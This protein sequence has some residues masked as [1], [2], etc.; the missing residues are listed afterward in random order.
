MP[1]W[2]GYRTAHGE[3]ARLAELG[4]LAIGWGRV[5]VAAAPR[6]P[7][8]SRASSCGPLHGRPY[9]VMLAVEEQPG[10]IPGAALRLLPPSHPS[11]HHGIR[12]PARSCAAS[13]RL[14]GRASAGLPP[15]TSCRPMPGCS[16]SSCSILT[17]RCQ[18][19]EFA[20]MGIASME[21][22]RL[23]RPPLWRGGRRKRAPLSHDS[24]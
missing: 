19:D 7:G 10:S 8:R 2:L 18:S 6:K 5:F 24:R 16:T 14:T 1:Y 20:D 12:G 11:S 9:L 23:A 21:A 15:S 13:N 17:R 22:R 4:R 3:A